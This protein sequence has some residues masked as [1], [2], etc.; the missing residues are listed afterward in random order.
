MLKPNSSK[1]LTVEFHKIPLGHLFHF[2][3]KK[4]SIFYFL[5]E[6]QI[7]ERLLLVMRYI[8]CQISVLTCL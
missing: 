4:K 7:L 1:K 5:E 8:G 6:V 2:K 3:K